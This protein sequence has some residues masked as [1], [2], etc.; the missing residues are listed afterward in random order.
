MVP[1]VSELIQFKDCPHFP[2]VSPDQSCK[3]CYCPIFPCRIQNTGGKYIETQTGHRLWDCSECTLIHDESVVKYLNLDPNEDN[4][5]R[6][7]E[8]KAKLRIY[9]AGV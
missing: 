7:R 5:Y 8:A 3:H 2:C 4:E 9:L 1:Q 6:L